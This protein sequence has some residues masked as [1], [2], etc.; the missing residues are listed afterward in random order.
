M[1]HTTGR[2][3]WS[4]QHELYPGYS[5]TSLEKNKRSIPR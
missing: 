5:T 4:I 2:F 1:M 3:L